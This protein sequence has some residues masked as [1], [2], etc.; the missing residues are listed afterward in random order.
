M[1]ELGVDPE[2]LSRLIGEGFLFNSAR[3]TENR[4]LKYPL[5]LE[6]SE[7]EQI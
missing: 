6:I 3:Y 2:I 7:M 4:K 5:N 1:A